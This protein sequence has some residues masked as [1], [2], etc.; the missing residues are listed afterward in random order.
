MAKQK[1]FPALIFFF[2][3]DSFLLMIFLFILE[4]ETLVTMCLILDFYN[5]FKE[6]GGFPGGPVVK[7]PPANARSIGS[8]PEDLQLSPCTPSTVPTL[9][10][11]VLHTREANAVGALGP[12]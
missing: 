2:L 7:N 10:E 4:P 3:S 12:R 11:P 9:L 5:H 6:Q 8:I 1:I